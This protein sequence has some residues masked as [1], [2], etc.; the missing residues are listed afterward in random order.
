[1]FPA[2]VQH[3]VQVGLCHAQVFEF[4]VR[5]F[6]GR[7]CFTPLLFEFSPLLFERVDARQFA[8]ES[9]RIEV[10][11]GDFAGFNNGAVRRCN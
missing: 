5:C 8:F 7:V 1:M 2:D 9:L 6:V 11:D 10:F 3:I 4:L